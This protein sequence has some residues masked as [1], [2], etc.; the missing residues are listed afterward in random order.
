MV[1]DI[2]YCSVVPNTVDCVQMVRGVA[3]RPEL[4]WI[5]SFLE[6]SGEKTVLLNLLL[7]LFNGTVLFVQCK[8]AWNPPGGNTETVFINFQGAQVCRANVHSFF[9]DCQSLRELRITSVLI[10]AAIQRRNVGGIQVQRPC[11]F[12][13]REEVFQI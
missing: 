3:P 4:P 7:Y 13:L 11:E 1:Q 6:I 8:L 5:Q 2:Q 10:I 12:F 9:I